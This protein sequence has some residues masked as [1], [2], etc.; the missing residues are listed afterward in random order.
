MLRRQE[1]TKGR[2]AVSPDWPSIA[3]ASSQLRPG[4]AAHAAKRGWRGR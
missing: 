1:I 3:L 2:H 4:R